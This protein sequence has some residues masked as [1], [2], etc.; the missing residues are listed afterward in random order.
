MGCTVGDVTL[1]TCFGLLGHVKGVK[2]TG[3]KGKCKRSKDKGKD[4]DKKENCEAKGSA[5][6]DDSY[7]AGE[8]GHCGKWRH[9]PGAGSIRRSK[10]ANLRL[11]RLKR[12]RW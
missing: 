12:L 5:A 8:C 4:R 6:T 1:A 7:S 11:Q 9:K 2:G 3:E 10:E